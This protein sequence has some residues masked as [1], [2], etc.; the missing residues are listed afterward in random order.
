MKVISTNLAKPVTIQWKGRSMQTGIFKVPQAKGILLTPRGVQG[1]TIGNPKVHGDWAKACYLFDFGDYPHWQSQYPDLNWEYGMF[2]EN[3]SLTG[4]DEGELL[5]GAV[6]RAGK[7]LLQITA[8]REP[9]FKLGVR[10]GD[11][12]IIDRFIAREKPGTYAAV[13]EEGW[14]KPGD[15]LTLEDVPETS[16]SIREFH[17]LLYTPEKDAEQLHKALS[18]PVLSDGKGKLFRRWLNA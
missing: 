16:M 10:F 9:C 2:G 7:A 5:I 13:L 18:L 14:L 12:K 17:T 15:H 3:I 1:D 4:L 8:P 6:Y 11:Q